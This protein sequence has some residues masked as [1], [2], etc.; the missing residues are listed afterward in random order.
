[1]FSPF[2]LTNKAPLTFINITMLKNIYKSMKKFIDFSCNAI[3]IVFIIF[4]YL[5][6]PVLIPTNLEVFILYILVD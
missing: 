2:L 5:L 4:L 3:N 6:S 1:M